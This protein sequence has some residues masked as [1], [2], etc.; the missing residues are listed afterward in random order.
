M[1]RNF[2]AFVII[3]NIYPAARNAAE[4][5]IKAIIY[6]KRQIIKHVEFLI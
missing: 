6:K 4:E 3:W 5:K 1:L 2:N